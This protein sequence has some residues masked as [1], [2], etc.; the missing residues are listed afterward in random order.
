MT[1]TNKG[2]IGTVLGLV[3]L[4]V[5]GL[6]LGVAALILGLVDNPKNTWSYVSIV[7]GAVDVVAVLYFLGSI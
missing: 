6:P 1:P 2:I 4:V 3:G 7:V 5:F